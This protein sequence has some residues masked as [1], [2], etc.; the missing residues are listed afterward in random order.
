MVDQISKLGG[1][2]N[3]QQVGAK[4][5]NEAKKPADNT[6]VSGFNTADEVSI[7]DEASALSDAQQ[8]AASA[9][10]ALESNPDVTLG[11][12]DTLKDL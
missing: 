12:V 5:Q 2:Q 9:R 10:L 1:V 8:Q 4:A 6:P 3:V 7:S 11:S